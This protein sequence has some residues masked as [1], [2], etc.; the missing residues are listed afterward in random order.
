MLADQLLAKMADETDLENRPVSE[1]PRAAGT[2]DPG[3]GG[4]ADGEQE[5]EWSNGLFSCDKECGTCKSSRA[6]VQ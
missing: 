3:A 4:Q 6:I 2:E 5:K 1:E